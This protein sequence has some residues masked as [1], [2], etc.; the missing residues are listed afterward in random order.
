MVA[1]HPAD[2][3]KRAPQTSLANLRKPDVTDGGR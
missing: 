1:L 2:N 3:G